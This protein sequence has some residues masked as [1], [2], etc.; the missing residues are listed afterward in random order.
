MLNMDTP[1][2]SVKTG[3]KTTYTH[4]IFRYS[5]AGAAPAT[6]SESAGA[7]MSL[8]A[9]MRPVSTNALTKRDLIRR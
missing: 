8:A 9:R 6:G 1:S 7:E 3:A 5:A 2:Q 4:G